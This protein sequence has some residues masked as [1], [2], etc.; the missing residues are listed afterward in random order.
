MAATQCA[1]DDGSHQQRQQNDRL[2]KGPCKEIFTA[3]KKC[4]AVKGAKN[5]MEELYS[6]PTETER[7]IKCM[8]KNPIYF[9]WGDVG[10]VD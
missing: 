7:L 1:P 5:H 4:S 10:S 2:G 9:Q 8:N 3:L 6:C